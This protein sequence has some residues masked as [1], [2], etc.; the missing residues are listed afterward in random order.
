MGFNSAFKGL[1][2]FLKKPGNGLLNNL[3]DPVHNVLKRAV[4]YSVNERCT[5]SVWHLGDIKPMARAKKTCLAVSCI[6]GPLHPWRSRHNDT[7]KRRESITQWRSSTECGI[8]NYMSVETIGPAS[9][10]GAAMECCEPRASWY[11]ADTFILILCEWPWA[12]SLA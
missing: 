12:I 11:T 4:L 7:P 10:C 1:K 3:N 6:C 9:T 8:F 2:L 5:H